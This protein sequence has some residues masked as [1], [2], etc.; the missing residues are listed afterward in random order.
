MSDRLDTAAKLNWKECDFVF[1]Y[2]YISSF[3]SPRARIW[4]FFGKFITLSNFHVN[5]QLTAPVRWWLFSLILVE[6]TG[7]MGNITN[8][9]YSERKVAAKHIRENSKLSAFV[10]PFFIHVTDDFARKSS[11]KTHK[12]CFLLCL[13][14]FIECFSLRSLW[15]FQWIW[16]LLCVTRI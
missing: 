10:T 8:I 1:L 12:I 7:W 13:Q 11:H 16:G 2:L 14:S 9:Y 3:R 6:K 4:I 15:R 5:S